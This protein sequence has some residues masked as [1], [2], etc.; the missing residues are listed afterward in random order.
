MVNVEWFAS[1]PCGGSTGHLQRDPGTCAAIIKV[2][3]SKG[4]AGVANRF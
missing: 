4:V 1:T 3:Q 2:T